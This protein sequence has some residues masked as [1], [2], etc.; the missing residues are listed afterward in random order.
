MGTGNNKKV[1]KYCLQ[2]LPAAI[3][4]NLHRSYTSV[5]NCRLICS[6]APSK[7]LKFWE[8]TWNMDCF[9]N[10]LYSIPSWTV[11][12]IRKISL[13]FVSQSERD[14]Y[15]IIL[16]RGCK[17]REDQRPLNRVLNS[18]D[19]SYKNQAAVY[20]RIPL[21]IKS[22]LTLW[23]IYASKKMWFNRIPVSL[24]RFWQAL[25]KSLSLYQEK[26]FGRSGLEHTS[27]GIHQKQAFWKGG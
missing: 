8:L 2:K 14:S 21:R 7:E 5:Y 25:P 26:F 3:N 23:L 15:R 1:Q 20:Q 19:F 9:H 16:V 27:V 6:C 11:T 12:R 22:F 24:G 18:P 13:L 4:C 10:K 17:K